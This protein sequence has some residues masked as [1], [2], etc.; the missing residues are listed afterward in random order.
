MLLTFFTLFMVSCKKY[1]E[2]KSNK[3]LVIPTT[4][5]DLQGILDDAAVM[6][7]QSTPGYMETAA[8]DYFLLPATL[9]TLVPAE[10]QLYAWKPVYYTYADD[11]SKGY[12]V[13]YNTNLC[14]ENLEKIEKTGINAA[15]WNNVKGSSL[16]FRAYY[17]LELAWEF[18]KAYDKRSSASDLG[19]VL[20]KG[21]DFNVP[22]V[23][24]NVKDT[25]EQIIQDAKESVACLPNTPLHVMRP[26]KAAAYGLL[27][28]TYLSMREIDSAYKYADLCLNLKNTLMNYNGDAD[29]T[30]ALT[31]NTLFKKFN[32]ET[33]FYTEMYA[34]FAL[35]VPSRGKIDPL[36]Y[37]QYDANDLRKTAFF[38]ANSG[39]QQFKGSYAASA[40]VLFTGIAVDEVYL[41]RAECLVRLNK[42]ADGMADLNLLLKNRYTTSTTAPILTATDQADA[43]GKVLTERR[44]E[45]LMRGLRWIDIKRLNKEDAN[46]TPSRTINGLTYTLQPNANFYALPLPSD[47]IE[48]TGIPQNPE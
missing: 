33:I 11:W 23:R 29:L 22:S 7:T 18:S 35:H 10:L 36:L 44:K 9:S 8:D 41:I 15:A 43:L 17:N 34:S 6:N 28:R 21:S 3:S 25:Y 13:V 27:A 37:A 38:K 42:V 4:L 40:S 2:E 5:E 30:G 48:L 24:S 46:I 12:S 26:S 20:R 31:S 19:I 32:K 14:L 45:I 16:F 47:I 39:Y 1:L